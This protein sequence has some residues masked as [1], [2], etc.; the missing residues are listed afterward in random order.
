[1]VNS[2]TCVLYELYEARWNGGSAKAGSGA[3]FDLSSDVLR[4][5]TW[6]SADAAGLPILPGLVRFDEVQ[7][8]SI[9]HAIRFTVSC[10]RNRFIRPAR[11]EAGVADRACPPMGARFRLKSSFDITGTGPTSRWCCARC[12]TTG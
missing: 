2:E 4:P 12:S 8:G 10:T 6:T 1:M 7:A 3:V 9:D 5:A 11:H